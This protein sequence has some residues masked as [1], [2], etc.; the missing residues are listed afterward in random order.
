MH[1]DINLTED[2]QQ[3]TQSPFMIFVQHQPS[4]PFY[5]PFVSKNNLITCCFS[6]AQFDSVRAPSCYRQAAAPL[7]A[8]TQVP[9]FSSPYIE[10]PPHYFVLTTGSTPEKGIK[11]E[12]AGALAGNIEPSKTSELERENGQPRVGNGTYMVG[13]VFVQESESK[14]D[15]TLDLPGIKVGDLQ[16]KHHS[17][18]GCLDIRAERKLGN[19]QTVST[20]SERL[21]FD[22]DLVD[23]S[24]TSARLM[25]GVLTI[26]VPKRKYCISAAKSTEKQPAVIHIPI[27]LSEPPAMADSNNSEYLVWTVDVPGVKSS[28]LNVEYYKGGTLLIKG[29]RIDRN[30]KVQHTLTLNEKEMESVS[31][32]STKSLQAFLMDGVLTICALRRQSTP[33]K[34][35]KVTTDDNDSPQSASSASG[36]KRGFLLHGTKKAEMQQTENESSKEQNKKVGEL[37]VK[38]SSDRYNLK[39]Q[40]PTRC[41]TNDIQI[42]E[43][44]GTVN[45]TAKCKSTS[46]QGTEPKHIERSKSFNIHTADFSRAVAELSD[47]GVLSIVIPKKTAANKP[48]SLHVVA[49]EPPAELSGEARNIYLIAEVP[50][51]KA[52]DLKA[53]Y[54]NGQITVE[55]QRK[56]R[57]G[58]H[59]EIR[60][61]LTVNDSEI[62]TNSLQAYL[63]DGVLIIKAP[64]REGTIAR[65]IQV[66][67]KTQTDST[68]RGLKRGFLL[69]ELASKE[70][71]KVIQNTSHHKQ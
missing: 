60:R 62:D 25:D 20:T 23:F 12:S 44:A 31:A 4:A 10:L 45:I 48:V 64:H 49:G 58:N 41:R 67:G 22:N 39:V 65:T 8:Q 14:Y 71:K 18:D 6:P 16:V 5:Q 28:D 36:L 30:A 52:C 32:T 53:S 9:M 43:L 50:G 29:K 68:K 40:L 42:T 69:G 24:K 57:T 27:A 47:Q 17:D 13:K 21:F 34:R 26:E 54:C 61:I 51:V 38:D 2:R 1:C 37:T 19:N 70:K 56:D 59:A 7:V 35:I 66:K 3:S 33:P 15:L 63:S 11:S 46:S 55:G